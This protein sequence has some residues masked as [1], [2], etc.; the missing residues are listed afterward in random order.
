M[1]GGLP[2]VDCDLVAD[3][4]EALFIAGNEQDVSTK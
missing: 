2:A 3:R 1:D 4:I